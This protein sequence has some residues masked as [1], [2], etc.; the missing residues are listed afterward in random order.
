MGPSER[1]DC[2]YYRQHFTAVNVS[3]TCQTSEVPTRTPSWCAV[4]AAADTPAHTFLS[5][6]THRETGWSA[7]LRPGQVTRPEDVWHSL[8]SFPESV[9]EPTEQAAALRTREGGPQLRW[10]RSKWLEVAFTGAASPGLPPEAVPPSPDHS[11]RYASQRGKARGI[12]RPCACHGCSPRLKGSERRW[13]CKLCGHSLAPPGQMSVRSPRTRHPTERSDGERWGNGCGESS[14]CA[15]NT[16][17]PQWGRRGVPDKAV[18]MD[19]QGQKPRDT[20][21]YHTTS[22]RHFLETEVTLR[23]LPHHTPGCSGRNSCPT[24]SHQHFQSPF[25]PV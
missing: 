4:A 17:T 13:R 25:L 22:R 9:T 21:T 16:H 14:D 20:N 11:P 24:P 12:P 18:G 19:C 2:F 7:S 15:A 8:R 23:M 10:N 3:G 1:G 5:Y 6:F